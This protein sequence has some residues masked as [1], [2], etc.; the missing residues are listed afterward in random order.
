MS[1]P[2]K[3]SRPRFHSGRKF[4]RK[5]VAFAL[6]LGSLVLQGGCSCGGGDS[7]SNPPLSACST[8]A[9]SSA[10]ATQCS[11]T[12]IQT[13]MATS[14]SCLA[15]GAPAACSGGNTCV[16]STNTCGPAPKQIVFT[17][18]TLA[19]LKQIQPD[20]TFGELVIDGQIGRAHV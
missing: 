4:P 12:Q 10:G 13:C 8:N 20:L 5:T 17:G 14:D 2:G 18:G 1:R 19:D 7:K 6:A 16:A 11:G 9:C 15:W 3:E